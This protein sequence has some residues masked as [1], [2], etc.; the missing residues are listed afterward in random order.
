V[1]DADGV[2]ITPEGG[3]ER[4]AD[5]SR[6]APVAH[7]ARLLH[8][9]VEGT[10]LPVQLRLLVL[11]EL[12][13]S[14][15][16]ASV[17]E[18]STRL[19]LFER[20][21]RQTLVRE[22]YERYQRLPPGDIETPAPEP[23]RTT[24]ISAPP[25]WRNRR[26]QG[27]AAAALLVVTLGLLL[28]W[29]RSSVAP[30]APGEAD[31][32]GP[33]ARELSAAVDSVSEAAS[34]SARAVSSWLGLARTDRPAATPVADAPGAPAQPAAPRARVFPEAAPPTAPRALVPVAPS[35]GASRAAAPSAEVLDSRVYSSVD[36]EVAPPALVRPRLPI[37]PSPEV[38]ADEIPEVEVVVSPAGEVES[39]KLLTRPTGVGAAM[40][41]S[42]VKTW[43]FHPAT[44]DGEP[45]RYR[46]LMRLTNQ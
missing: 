14:P 38:R 21:D 8:G 37:A 15:G 40:M 32:R 19:A 31:Q 6:D 27:A 24:E 42:A 45:V 26:I 18:F 43:R 41:L 34:G 36:A 12:S 46:L 1:P 35:A 44:R 29:V 2:A 17:L 5:G 22:V 7:V 11:Q 30:P 9:L 13:P 4:L 25:W 3:I 20:P 10:A 39:V 28:A 23:A 33:V 16:C